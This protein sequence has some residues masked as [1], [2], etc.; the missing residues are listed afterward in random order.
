MYYLKYLDV[1]LIV[2]IVVITAEIP[3]KKNGLIFNKYVKLYTFPMLPYPILPA[4][5]YSFFNTLK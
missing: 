1:F 3:L 4:F 2:T 5:L